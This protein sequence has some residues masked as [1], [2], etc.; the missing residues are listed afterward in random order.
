MTERPRRPRV[1]P[2]LLGSIA[3]FG[4]VFL[5]L[6]FQLAGGHD[7]ALGTTSAAAKHK[8]PAITAPAPPPAPPVVVTSS[9]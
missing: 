1:W 6:A 4:I 2:V 8:A 9:S 5:L 3:M 7:P